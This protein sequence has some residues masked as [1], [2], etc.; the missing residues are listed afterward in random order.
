MIDDLGVKVLCAI[1]EDDAFALRCLRF[2]VHR[3][4]ADEILEG[5]SLHRNGRGLSKPHAEMLAGRDPET[6][7]AA[8]VSRIA[9]E[10]AHSQLADAVRNKELRMTGACREHRRSELLPG[11]LASA[12]GDETLVRVGLGSKRRRG[13]QVLQSEDEDEDEEPELPDS[14]EDDLCLDEYG[15]HFGGVVMPSASFV[16]R[17]GRIVRDLRTRDEPASAFPRRV[18]RIVNAEDGW[19]GTNV[20]ARMVDAALY[21]VMP[22]VD[23]FLA[24]PKTLVRIFW[25]SEG[26]WATAE[27]V[28]VRRGSDTTNVVELFFPDEEVDGTV[29]GADTLYAYKLE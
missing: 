23:L 6:M 15:V 12:G 11:A 21:Q 2:L 3:Q 19:R 17:V 28:R 4:D 10:Y 8:D 29:T 25:I 9:S 18:A 22:A 7:P 16:S 27:T 26:R 1:R 20:S 14:S 5:T 24:R 13:R